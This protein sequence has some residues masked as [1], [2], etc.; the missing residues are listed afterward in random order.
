MSVSPPIN[1]YTPYKNYEKRFFVSYGKRFFD[2]GNGI[3]FV[4]TVGTNHL[5]TSKSDVFL[6]NSRPI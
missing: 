4:N 5:I 6:R 3:D 1:L 2:K